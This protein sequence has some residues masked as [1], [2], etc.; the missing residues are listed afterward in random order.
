MLDRKRSTLQQA[1]TI[2]PRVILTNCP[3]CIQGLGRNQDTGITPR[4]IAV[5]LALK[6][7]GEN[8]A[9]EF[10]KLLANAEAITF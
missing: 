4:H 2:G 9:D 8:W 6:T 7:G 1:A 5:E 3:A 10:A